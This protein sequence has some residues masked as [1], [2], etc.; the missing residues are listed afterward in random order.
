MDYSFATEDATC[1]QFPIFP[2]TAS[3]IKNLGLTGA[4]TN[5]V[6]C[7]PCYYGNSG[8][9]NGFKHSGEYDAELISYSKKT[10]I[11]PCFIMKADS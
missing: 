8:Y 10:G 1:K 5:W 3:R 9:V 7:S 11:L 2:T 4:A 6:T